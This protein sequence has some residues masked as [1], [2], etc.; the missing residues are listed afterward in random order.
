MDVDEV[1]LDLKELVKG[2]YHWFEFYASKESL[3]TYHL[4]EEH[5]ENFMIFNPK[6]FSHQ[7]QQLN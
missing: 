4:I 7:I 5:L 1:Y 3:Q 6:H 2:N